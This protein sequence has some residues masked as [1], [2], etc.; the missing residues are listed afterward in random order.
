MLDI[1]KYFEEKFGMT[2]DAARNEHMKFTAIGLCKF[3]RE[4]H[5]DNLQNEIKNCTTCKHIEVS[6]YLEPCYSCIS[7]NNDEIYDNY[8]KE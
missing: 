7:D 3:V 1:E 4:Y 6:K 5:Y 2:V 8:E